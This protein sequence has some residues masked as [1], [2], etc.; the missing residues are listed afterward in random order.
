MAEKVYLTIKGIQRG[1]GQEDV[2]EVATTGDYFKKGN[3]HYVFYKEYQEDGS[4][5]SNRLTV[6]P[7][8]AQLKKTGA[9]NSELNFREGHSEPC[10]YQ[11][12]VGPMDLVSNT[13]KI[14]ILEKENQMRFML[15][16]SLYMGGSIMSEYELKVECRFLQEE[17]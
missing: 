9:G 5:T 13:R 3:K 8:F 16:Y 1:F 15:F 4:M 14:K 17:T 11:S 2:N 6:E 10:I 12:A 7:G